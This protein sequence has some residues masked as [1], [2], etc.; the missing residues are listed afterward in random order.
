MRSSPTATRAGEPTELPAPAGRAPLGGDTGGQRTGQH[1]PDGQAV[2]RRRGRPTRP[3]PRPRRCGPPT[4]PGSVRSGRGQL[5]GTS[6]PTAPRPQSCAGCG[7]GTVVAARLDRPAAGGGDGQCRPHAGRRAQRRCPPHQRVVASSSEVLLVGSAPAAAEVANLR[8][9][10]L[11]VWAAVRRSSAPQG[12]AGGDEAGDGPSD[13]V[14]HEIATR[15][16]VPTHVGGGGDMRCRELHD[17]VEGTDTHGC[18]PGDGPC[19]RPS[20]TRPMDAVRDS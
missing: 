3:R 20:R 4:A 16:L 10:R 17:L 1:A 19:L 9:A 11:G 14:G 13:H 6:S 15:V 18:Q 7:T 8:L 5:V 2:R 12:P